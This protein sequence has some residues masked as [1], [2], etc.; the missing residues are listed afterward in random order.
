MFDAATLR[1]PWM[2]PSCTGIQRLPGRSNLLPYPSI[3]S[4]LT[5]D[6]ASTPWRMDLNG[7]W[8]FLLAPRP[9]ALPQDFAATTCDDKAWK[10]LR[11][12]C[13]WNL[14]DVN[15]PPIY[16]NHVMPWENTPPTVPDDNPTGVY[17]RSITV[18]ANW[19]GRRIVLHIAG[20]ESVVVVYVNGEEVGLGKD[21]RLPSEFDITSYCT[22]GERT[23]I[24]L[25]VIRWSDGSFLEDQDHWWMAGLH[26]DVYLYS[27][28]ETHIHDLQIQ[29]DYDYEKSSGQLHCLVEVSGDVQ[30]L[31]GC[32]VEGRLFDSQGKEVLEAPLMGDASSGLTFLRDDIKRIGRVKSM[33][34]LTATLENPAPWSDETPSLYQLV[35]SLRDPEGKVLECTTDRLGFRRIEIKDR[36]ILVNGKAIFLRGVN[37]H[38]HHPRFGKTVPVETMIQDLE[39]LKRFNFNAVRTSHYPNDALWYELCD[40]Y[41][42][43]V[44]DEANLECH[45]YQNPHVWH[46][47]RDPAWSLAFLDRGQRMLLRDK[48]RPSILMWSLGNESGYGANHD[49]MAAWMRS[50]DPTRLIH[51]EGAIQEWRQNDGCRYGGIDY[52]HGQVGTDVICPMYPHPD[53]VKEFNTRT[54]D[55]RPFLL[56]EYSHAMGNSNGSLREYWEVFE[57]TPGCC[58]GFIW[59]WVDQG[60]DQV[61]ADGNPYWAFGGDF[62]ERIHDFD[63]CINGLIWPDRSPHPAMY[64][65]KRLVQPAAIQLLSQQSDHIEIEIRSKRCFT[66]LDELALSWQLRVDGICQLSGKVDTLDIPPEESKNISLP[67]KMPEI[68]A[69][70]EVTLDITLVLKQDNRWAEAGHVVVT[71][72]LPLSVAASLEIPALRSKSEV[73]LRNDGASTDELTFALN[74]QG[75][76][77]SFKFKNKELLARPF[78]L[79]LF[80]ATTDNDCIRG[81]SGQEKKPG[82]RWLAYGLHQLQHRCIESTEKAGKLIAHCEATGLQ[83]L[84]LAYTLSYQLSPLGVLSVELQIDLPEALSDVARIGLYGALSKGMEQTEWLGRG[85][86]ENYCD[87]QSAADLGR[88]TASV[89]DLYTPYILPQEN[90]HRGDCRWLS[91]SDGEQG[92]LAVAES[93]SATGFGFNAGH[94]EINELATNIHPTDMTRSEETFLHLDLLQR[95]VGTGSCGPDTLDAYRIPS[96]P[97]RFC[98]HLAAVDNRHHLNDLAR[99]IQASL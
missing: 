63:F 7:K 2:D 11:V 74:A 26:R 31:D 59:D 70:Q 93:S 71:E 50:Y 24:T 55:P 23:L 1:K 69:G 16:T 17:R 80:R 77:Q 58:G 84:K 64:E 28:S 39:L 30:K 32:T 3:E 85:P 9:E 18:P 44:V 6:P 88:Y 52:E 86:V 42:I 33:V 83:E 65:H 95:G 8:R 5:R 20:F 27:Q 56:C 66:H 46:L 47:A 10:E 15:D 82:G 45:N 68:Y 75:Q 72:Q 97:H 81:W 19:T 98:V 34:E 61:D 43:Y 14:Q 94:F 54:Q 57:N 37:R 51:Y 79:C 90:G 13:N 96:G 53:K 21:S 62:G 89:D 48:N 36:R 12:P 40:E 25:M 87:R 78:E 91:V 99:M 29:A 73:T 92:L 41:G 35:V 67:V 60:L 4:A 76:L 49:A 38:D 22:A